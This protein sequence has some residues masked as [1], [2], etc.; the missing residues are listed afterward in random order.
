[1]S[2]VKI[3]NTTPNQIETIKPVVSK[4]LQSIDNENINNNNEKINNNNENYYNE[5]IND[6]ISSEFDPSKEPTILYL[7]N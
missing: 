7:D 6:Y 5:V 1:M 4:P 2:D 3:E